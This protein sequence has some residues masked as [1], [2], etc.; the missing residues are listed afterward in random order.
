MADREPLE[1]LEPLF[2]TAAELMPPPGT[3]DAIRRRARGI[4]RRRRA[5]L[6]AG[7]VA[8]AS[9]LFLQLGHVEGTSSL[10]PANDPVTKTIAPAPL[11]T[12]GTAPVTTGPP[13]QVTG[14]HQQPVREPARPRTATSGAVRPPVVRPTARTEPYGTF[15]IYIRTAQ[16]NEA[17]TAGLTCDASAGWSP[18]PGGWCLKTTDHSNDTTAAPTNL[19]DQWW[20]G[21]WM[22][23]PPRSGSGTV[24][25]TSPPH[26]RV[27]TPSGALMFDTRTRWR[28]QSPVYAQSTPGQV[29]ESACQYVA[30]G[31]DSRDDAGVLVPEGRYRYD[32]DFGDA[33]FEQWNA[34]HSGPEISVTYGNVH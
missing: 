5:T 11:S 7:S 30:V 19:A 1:P 24:D 23:R 25:F 17:P 15:R 22:C 18:G 20:L 16:V 3:A 34:A 21:V 33:T 31:W 26:L 2:V 32:F 14:T 9:L 10:R 28:G 4:R 13:V 6:S 27:R 29:A 8:A 12:R